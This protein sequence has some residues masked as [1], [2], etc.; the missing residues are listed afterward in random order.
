MRTSTEEDGRF[1][2]AVLASPEMQAQL[3]AIDRPDRF[4][5][6]AR[7][8]ATELGLI[9][10]DRSASY[11]TPIERDHWPDRGWLP[12]RSIATAGALAFDWAWFGERRLTEPFY[13]DS[14]RHMA[15]RPFSHAFRVRT[16]LDALVAG[17]AREATLAPAGLIFHMSRCGSTLAA[18]M[19][20]AV[21]HHIVVAEAEPI[22]AVVQWAA[23]PGIP[24]DRQVAALRA[25]VAA[26]GRDRGGS[27]RRYFLKLDAWHILSLPLYRAAFPNVPWV[28][29][30]RDPEEVMVSQMRLAGT[31]FAGGVPGI[32]ALEDGTPFSREGYGAQVLGRLLCAA[33]EHYD[34]RDGLLINYNALVARMAD[35]IPAHFGFAPNEQERAAMSAAA[36]RDAKAPD[37]RFA[38]DGS[39]KRAAVNA[40][41]RAAVQA[42]LAQPYARLEQLRRED[43]HD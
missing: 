3:G 42:H 27:A 26:F 14:V 10:P 36:L 1:R 6:E 37:R 25:I 8:V 17:A 31:H 22:D 23:T 38:A 40:A 15:S 13:A 43:R 29:L 18:Q 4:E 33:L 7:A 19:L 32:A 41:I 21:P 11:G 2:D 5:D 16:G 28:F 30:Y 35:V 34:R 9:V 20:A 39:T 24:V 12:A